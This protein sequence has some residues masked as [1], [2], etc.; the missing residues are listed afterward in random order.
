MEN[1]KILTFL[2]SLYASLVF[3][4]SKLDLFFSEIE[5][6]NLPKRILLGTNLD[7]RNLE[8]DREES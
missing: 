3:T 5:A 6:M 4:L 7:E 8:K 2:K 1:I